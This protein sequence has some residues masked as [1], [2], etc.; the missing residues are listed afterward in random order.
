MADTIQAIRTADGDKQYDY[1]GLA[2]KPTIPSSTSELT[3]DSDF[4][5]A[6]QVTATV[7][8]K[9]AE[10]IAEAPE[11]FDTLKEIADWIE[12][13]ASS[14]AE[15]NSAIKQNATDIQTLKD[16]K[17]EKDEATTTTAGLMSSTDKV[18]LD[19]IAEGA[20]V[21]VQ[22]DWS[23]TDETADDYIKNKPTSD[24]TLSVEGGFADGKATGEAIEKNANDITTILKAMGDL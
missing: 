20:E 19:G 8:A 9:I 6:S 7:A 5:T 24:T 2:N 3:N 10:I 22:S 4:Q 18:K 16:T 23:S 13:H 12:S 15:M 17:A 14:A 21:N 11:S 1:N